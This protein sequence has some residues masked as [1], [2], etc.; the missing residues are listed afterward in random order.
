MDVEVIIT[1]PSDQSHSKRCAA[2]VEIN[3]QRVDLAE[4][5]ASVEAR[6]TQPDGE[7]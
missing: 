7:G 1:A 5:I 6:L 2:S 3:G 4:W